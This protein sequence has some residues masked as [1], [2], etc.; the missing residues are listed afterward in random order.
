[1][2]TRPAA[3]LRKAKVPV[4]S[5][6]C[7]G[8]L[9][10]KDARFHPGREW[11]SERRQRWAETMTGPANYAWKGGVTVFK[12][13]GNYSGVKYVRAPEWAKPMARK[14]GYVMEHRLIMAQTCG[15]LLLRTETVHHVNH[16]PTDN[17]PENLLL[18][19]DNR[20]HKLYEWGRPL[21]LGACNRTRY[22]SLTTPVSSG[23]SPFL[24]GLSLL[25]VMGLCS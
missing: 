5:R 2:F 22:A 6:L 25:D 20:T 1:M 9:R 17:R 18:C 8:K 24:R 3:W 23:A 19:P 12:K 15:F 10:I 14:D 7:N 16:D 11:S 4:C 21:P 13:H